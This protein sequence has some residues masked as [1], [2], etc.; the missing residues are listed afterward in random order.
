MCGAARPVQVAER[1]VSGVIRD[2]EHVTLEAEQLP[3]HGFC[4]VT[5]VVSWKRR[6]GKWF[7]AGNEKCGNCTWESQNA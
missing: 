3:D 5:D 7:D 1:P 4:V 6:K 2:I